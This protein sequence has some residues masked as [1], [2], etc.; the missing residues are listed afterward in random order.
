MRFTTHLATPTTNLTTPQAHNMQMS[1]GPL[2]SPT[3]TTM[4]MMNMSIMM[5]MTMITIIAH[6]F[7]V[8]TAT[9]A[10]L[11]TMTPFM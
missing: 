2:K 8:S 7:V 3:T 4:E 5:M 11:V 1:T 9:I 10:D 6:G